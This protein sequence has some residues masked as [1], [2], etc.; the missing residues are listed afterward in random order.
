MESVAS[1][2]VFGFGFGLLRAGTRIKLFQPNSSAGG[3]L[4]LVAAPVYV[5]LVP[6]GGRDTAA[7]F[8]F[9]CLA[10]APLWLWIRAASL[11]QKMSAQQTHRALEM[12][13][14]VSRVLII[15]AVLATPVILLIKAQ[16]AGVRLPGLLALL[17]F[18]IAAAQITAYSLAVASITQQTVLTAQE[19]HA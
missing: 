19:G 16:F 18:S 14:R 13:L 1:P 11:R 8:S 3:W 9:C 10:G 7:F 12:P 15:C 4:L 6:S 5:L 17:A 2:L